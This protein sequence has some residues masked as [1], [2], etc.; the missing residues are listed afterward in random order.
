MYGDWLFF[1]ETFMKVL[2]FEHLRDRV[3]GR[4][5]NEVVGCELRK[6]AAIEINDCLLR[7]KN[8]EDLSLVSL[9][10]LLD[11]F[12]GQAAVA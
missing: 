4:Q 5:A 7:I 8:L 1:E 3:F 10:I 6:P 2:T 12:A 11:L 9:G